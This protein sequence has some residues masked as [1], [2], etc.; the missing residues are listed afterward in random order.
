M[1][2]DNS[3]PQ[4]DYTRLLFNRRAKP[5]KLN[6]NYT[7]TTTTAATT[8]TTTT[9]NNNEGQEAL[10][11]MKSLLSTQFENEIMQTCDKYM[12][13]FQRA[14]SNIECNQGEHVPQILL[15]SVLQT[16]L[17]STRNVVSRRYSHYKPT[18]NTQGIKLRTMKVVRRKPRTLENQRMNWLKQIRRSSAGHTE[19]VEESNN[20]WPSV[21]PVDNTGKASLEETIDTNCN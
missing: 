8:T 21:K 2:P 1:E 9:T 12:E 14:G 20:L 18:G 6:N 4:L 19:S 3:S 11:V 13:M 10:E 5:N 16:M 7:T 17:K 15:T